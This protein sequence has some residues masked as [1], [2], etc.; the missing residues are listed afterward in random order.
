[1][2]NSRLPVSEINSQQA[3]TMVPVSTV[4]VPTE[5]YVID[6][7]IS[8]FTARAFAT[9]LLSV[10]GHS[11]TIGIHGF[12]G[13]VHLPPDSLDGASLHLKIEGS[14][15]AVL[16]QI[17]DKDRRE[18][19]RQM[20]D[21]VLET[22]RFPQIVYECARVTGQAGAGE[23]GVTLDGQLTLHG[24]TRSQPVEA[25]VTVMGSLLRA[26]GEFTVRQ[27]DYNIKPVSSVGGTLKLKDELKLAFDIAARKQKQE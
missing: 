22:A 9:G 27:S 8:R 11:P 13:E 25:R 23:Y 10:L 4:K 18:M 7:G 14:S 19:E 12:G 6:P 17:S 2:Q 24:V 26:S 5:E 20:R 21:E 1:V 15:L 3:R 16:D